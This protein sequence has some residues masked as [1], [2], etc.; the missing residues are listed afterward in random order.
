[1]Q[2]RLSVLISKM[3]NLGVR[4]PFNLYESYLQIVCGKLHIP[5]H[6][7]DLIPKNW[8]DTSCTSADTLGNAYLTSFFVSGAWDR[9]KL[10]Q[11]LKSYQNAV[12]EIFAEL[13]LN[14]RSPMGAEVFHMQ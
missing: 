5:R 14:A 6:E 9:N 7:F 1:M 2:S 13:S 4:L 10:H 11:S 3:A 8:I 12:S